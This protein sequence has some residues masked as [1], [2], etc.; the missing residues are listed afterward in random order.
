MTIN[1][2]SWIDEDREHELREKIVHT[3]IEKRNLFESI[4]WIT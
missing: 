2:K 1:I 4:K 3:E